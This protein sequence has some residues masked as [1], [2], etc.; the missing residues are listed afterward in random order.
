[1]KWRIP[2]NGEN[3]YTSDGGGHSTLYPITTLSIQ[4]TYLLRSSCTFFFRPY[5]VPSLFPLLTPTSSHRSCIIQFLNF[6]YLAW[7]LHHYEA[8]D[9]AKSANADTKKVID[10]R[11]GPVHQPLSSSASLLLIFWATFW[12]AGPAYNV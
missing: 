1:M 3:G 6:L 10:G 11:T 2:S 9:G 5:L 8:P 4:V 12:F 7:I